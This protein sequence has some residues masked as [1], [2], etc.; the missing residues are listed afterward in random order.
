MSKQKKKQ[1]N[2]SVKVD[3]KKKVVYGCYVYCHFFPL[4]YG[5]YE[6]VLIILKK[7][8]KTV[9]GFVHKASD[10]VKSLLTCPDSALTEINIKVRNLLML[11]KI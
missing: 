11:I 9:L 1:G 5:N 7:K 2:V 8:R 4:N 3:A 10:R 6:M